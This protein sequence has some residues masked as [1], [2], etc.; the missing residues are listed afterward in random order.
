MNSINNLKAKCNQ[1]ERNLEDLEIRIGSKYAVLI[2][3]IREESATCVNSQIIDLSRQIH[4]MK[5]CK[6]I[7]QRHITMC[8]MEMRQIRESLRNE[9]VDVDEIVDVDDADY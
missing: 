5:K 2:N 1:Y 7:Y 8:Q 9:V 4:E 6:E 3:T